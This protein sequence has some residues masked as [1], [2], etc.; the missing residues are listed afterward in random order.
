MDTT[1][2]RNSLLL[3][4]VGGAAVLAVGGV[5]LGVNA[6][7]GSRA[8]ATALAAVTAEPTTTDAPDDSATSGTA[9]APGTSGTPS[10]A[11]PSSNAPS[12]G[13]PSGGGS[14]A[15]G[16]VDEQRAGEIALA[17]AGGGQ[18]VEVEAEQEHGRPVWSVEI[19]A[20]DTEHEVDV[21]RDNGTV[22]KAEQE[23][24]DDDGDDRDDSDDSDGDDDD[25]SG[26]DD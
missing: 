4:S 5:A 19:V 10:S 20:G 15:A 13:A 12:S 3:A 8:G 6:A 9:P 22:V 26:D 16:A 21:D 23:P 7:D 2:K 11:A 25:G 1:M 14:P 17:R 18:I 24:V